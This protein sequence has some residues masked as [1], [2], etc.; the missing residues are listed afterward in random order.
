M[1]K[2]LLYFICFLLCACG[3]SNSRRENEKKVSQSDL[4]KKQATG[5][6]LIK[7]TCYYS[8]EFADNLTVYFSGIDED[9][10]V[11]GATFDEDEILP[12]ISYGTGFFVSEDG[13][14]ATNSHVAFP[15][16][17]T[18]DARSSILSA[19][20]TLAEEIQDQ[21]NLQNE[22]LGELRLL[23]DAGNTNYISRYNALKEARDQNQVFVNVVSRLNSSD[24][25]YSRHCDIG[26]AL[27]NTHVRSTEDFLDCVPIAD[28]ADNDLAL[29]Q[30]KSKETPSKCHVFKV[31]SSK[32][33]NKRKSTRNRDE[34]DARE[35]KRSRSSLT[36]KTLYMIGYNLG[37]KLALTKEGIKAQ[38]TKGEI[39]QDTD[40]DKFM[41]T[42]PSLHG[43]SGSPV[44][45]VYGKLIA[46]NF[47]GIDTTQGFNYGIKAYHLADLIEENL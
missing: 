31:A 39:S 8:I 40:A 4:E 47:A 34:D 2:C 45:D 25:E 29:I 15:T 13:V 1:K 44:V 28:D 3:G 17:S 12:T 32:R 11:V 35:T 27:N 24:C 26:V 46:I 14:I 18:K 37:P 41:Y 16:F 43:S 23:I 7:N 19:F 10:D 21:I 9:G 20:Y 36:G 22:K 5:V 33:D 42:I 6:V 30:L 38:I